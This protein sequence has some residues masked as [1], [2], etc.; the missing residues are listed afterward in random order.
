VSIQWEGLHALRYGTFENALEKRQRSLELSKKLN[1]QSDIAWHHY[2]LGEIYRVFGQLE[3]A[4]ELYEQANTD[5]EKMNLILG[6]GY[7]QRAQ[8][9]IALH[10]GHYQEALQRYQAF[11]RYVI[12]DNHRWSIQQAHAKLALAH[13]YLQNRAEARAEMKIALDKMQ[14][15]GEKDLELE[16]LLAE[17]V[18]LMKEERPEQ[19]VELAAFIAHHPVSWNETK[20]LAGA[21]LETAGRGLSPAVVQAA[22]ESGQAMNL[23]RIVA[24][25]T[26]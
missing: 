16:V 6:K 11:N 4:L 7:Y 8:G 17:A 18:C 19:A 2:E 1:V 9:D 15:V 12:Q 5:F 13:A 24:N 10:S 23:D 21:M 3:N 25:L 20:Q 26:D 14:Q 22:I